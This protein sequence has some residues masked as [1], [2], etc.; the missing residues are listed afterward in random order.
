MSHLDYLIERML[1]SGLHDPS[2]LLKF[3]CQFLNKEVLV[4]VLLPADRRH[5]SVV[6]AG[7]P[8]DVITLVCADDTE[9]LPFFTSPSRL[10]RWQPTGAQCVLMYVRELFE[11]RPDMHFWLNPRSPDSYLFS[12]SEVHSLLK[13]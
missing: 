7:D 8:F 2:Q 3:Y 11:S 9:A 6:P 12:L 1:R 10:Y 5:P 13:Q 4:P